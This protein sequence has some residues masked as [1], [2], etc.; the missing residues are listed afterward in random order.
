[1]Q[2]EVGDKVV[3]ARYGPGRIAGV[4]EQDLAD[5]PRSYYVI[6]M[7]AKGLTVHVPVVK[8]DKAAVRPAMAPPAVAQVLKVLGRRP[9]RLPDDP[10]E[11]QELVG[12]KVKTGD[13]MQL[14][15]AVRDLTRH[16][17]RAHL[18]KVDTDLLKQGQEL[19]AAEM[20]L[21]SEGDVA[22]ASKLITSTLA[23]TAVGAA[24]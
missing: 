23:A 18:T 11:R 16:G 8:A 21:V 4:E 22:D 5:G 13:V 12:A 9:Q 19:L 24:S 17:E 15:K 20:A 2:Y 6:E 10:R 7:M 3:H 14:A 1:M